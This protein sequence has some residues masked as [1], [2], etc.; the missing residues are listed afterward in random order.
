LLSK[1]QA[2]LEHSRAARK[3]QALAALRGKKEL[4]SVLQRRLG[5][6]AT[7]GGVLLKIE[8]AAGDVEVCVCCVAPP[9][10][11]SIPFPLLLPS[12]ANSRVSC[13]CWAF[14]RC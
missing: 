13:V 14:T 6:E 1:K 9:P 8:Q 11:L 12:T 10:P 2:A 7:L 5:A 3:A 4:E